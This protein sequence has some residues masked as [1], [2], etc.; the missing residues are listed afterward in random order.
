MR[1]HYSYST[2]TFFPCCRRAPKTP[3]ELILPRDES[4]LM[5]KAC[6]AAETVLPGEANC[7]LIKSLLS[8][9]TWSF[10]LL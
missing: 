7:V 9:N 1:A 4:K 3:Q 8:G 2:I 5:Q 6:S 10:V